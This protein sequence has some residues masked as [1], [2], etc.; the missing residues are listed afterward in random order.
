MKMNKAEESYKKDVY[1]QLV[2]TDYSSNFTG[3]MLQ[4]NHKIVKKL[5]RELEDRNNIDSINERDMLWVNQLSSSGYI[6]P[7]KIIR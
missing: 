2:K 1:N 6:T 4:L 7:I 5:K 3:S